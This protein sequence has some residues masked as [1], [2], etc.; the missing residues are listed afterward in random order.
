MPDLLEV[1]AEHDTAVLNDWAAV[2]RERVPQIGTL[3]DREQL[4]ELLTFARE[5]SRLAAW[6]RETIEGWLTE[7]KNRLRDGMGGNKFRVHLKGGRKLCGVCHSIAEVAD[8]L[9]QL[10]QT[11]GAPVTEVQSARDTLAF[12]GQRIGLVETEIETFA[13]LAQPPSPEMVEQLFQRAEEQS[14]GKGLTRE[15]ALAAIRKSE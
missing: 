14:Q 2:F 3:P 10:A 8:E 1:I 4:R 11:A 7:L 15:Q 13:R 6:A 5:A 9:W 12:N